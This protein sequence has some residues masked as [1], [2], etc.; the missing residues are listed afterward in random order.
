MK[1]VNT[2]EE[3]ISGFPHQTQ[4]KLRELRK[5]IHQ[6]APEA[7]EGISYGMPAYKG[8]SVLF[9]FGGFK[10]HV[11]FFPTAKG[12]IPFKKELSKYKTSKGTIQFPIDE[13][14]PIELI[15]RIILT[16]VNDD[17]S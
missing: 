17:N 16:R 6:F 12:I 7:K 11:S 5:I 2:V 8:K 14:L 3:Y 13:D 10:A 15:K 4:K 1:T 9:Y